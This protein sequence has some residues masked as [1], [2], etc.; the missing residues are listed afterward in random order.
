VERGWSSGGRSSNEQPTSKPVIAAKIGSKRCSKLQCNF[1][2]TQFYSDW[3]A[4][5]TAGGAQI[6]F[7]VGFY[8]YV[9][10][11]RCEAS[12]GYSRSNRVG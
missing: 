2:Y 12:R 6:I 3:R 11:A 4:T 7:M 9:A 5:Y 10:V 1:N 8:S